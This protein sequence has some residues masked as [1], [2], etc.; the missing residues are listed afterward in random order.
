[1]GGICSPTTNQTRPPAK[2]T[3]TAVSMPVPPE[4]VVVVATVEFSVNVTVMLALSDVYASKVWSSKITVP[5]SVPTVAD[6]VT[7]EGVG[8]FGMVVSVLSLMHWQ[9]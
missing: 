4:S 7:W 2:M 3:A 6:E 9:K 5:E 8:V 1:V